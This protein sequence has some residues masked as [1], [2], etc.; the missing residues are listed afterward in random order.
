MSTHYLALLRGINVG[1]KNILKMAELR[2]CFEDMGFDD[3]ATYIQSGNVLFTASGRSRRRL[4]GEIEKALSRRFDY[5]SRLVVVS[6]NELDNVVKDS[7]KGF[8]EKPGEYRYDVIFLKEPLTAREAMK[9][10]RTR[11]GV[12]EA[13]VGKGVLYFS[14]LTAKAT[15]SHLPKLTQLP[16]YQQMTVRNWNTTTK[17]LSLLRKRVGEQKR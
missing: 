17:L 10:V 12:D 5:T 8:G 6:Q 15:Q 11:E 13:H 9:S 14:R 7:P 2:A 3:V 4:V 1:G 16:I